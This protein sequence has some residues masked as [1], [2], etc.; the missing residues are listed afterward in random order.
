MIKEKHHYNMSFSFWRYGQKITYLTALATLLAITVTTICRLCQPG[1][2]YVSYSQLEGN[3]DAC[4]AWW[5]IGS[6]EQSLLPSWN[7]KTK[8]EEKLLKGS[9]RW[10]C[11]R[12]SWPTVTLLE[13]PEDTRFVKDTKKIFIELLLFCCDDWNAI[14][15]R[16]H[17]CIWTY[18]LDLVF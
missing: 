1:V 8:C 7:L 5:E 14:F 12:E 15:L 13:A 9:V 3:S 10:Q 16:R 17:R 4:N 2:N 11:F 18:Y 6:S